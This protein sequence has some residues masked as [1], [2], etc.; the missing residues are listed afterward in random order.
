M[1]QRTDS[2]SNTCT[3]RKQCA[4]CP[5]K[6]TVDPMTI[7]NGY[8]RDKHAALKRTIAADLSRR[9][10][11]AMACH[12]TPVGAE[13]HCIGWL[14]HQLWVGNNLALRI[15]VISGR[16]NGDYALDGSQHATFEATLPEA[17]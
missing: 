7:P 6:A 15:A 5:W 4:K 11:D 2:G 12:E 3:R 14:H 1:N 17:R 9:P 8:S 16:V 10:T 13:R